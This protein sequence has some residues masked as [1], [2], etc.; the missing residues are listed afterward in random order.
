MKFQE[1]ITMTSKHKIVQPEVFEWKK[2]YVW[3]RLIER[4]RC[5]TYQMMRSVCMLEWIDTTVNK[6]VRV[7]KARVRY[8]VGTVGGNMYGC[9]RT[10]WPDGEIICLIFGH[11][12]QWE[13]A[14]FNFKFDKVSSQ[15]CQIQNEPIQ[16]LPKLIYVVMSGNISPNLVTLFSGPN[17]LTD[18]CCQRLLTVNMFKRLPMSFPTSQ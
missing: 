1:D 17:V 11:F 13:F 12:H 18:F 5:C 6:V 4:E 15:F 10:V 8:H 3:E 14:L 9:F 7:D 2:E 16:I